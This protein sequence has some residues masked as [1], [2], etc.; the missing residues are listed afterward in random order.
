MKD[1]E[2]VVG[3]RIH[4][5]ELQLRRGQWRSRNAV[6]SKIPWRRRMSLALFGCKMALLVRFLPGFKGLLVMRPQ[7]D[8][9]TE[10]RLPR[11]CE[12]TT[13]W[14]SGRLVTA[15]CGPRWERRPEGEELPWAGPIH[16]ALGGRPAPANSI[17]EK[18]SEWLGCDWPSDQNPS[19]F[20]AAKI[21]SSGGSS[22]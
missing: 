13:G 6:F 14:P 18:A 5:S 3:G 9:F 22:T 11:L 16:V 20:S 1:S 8:P 7:R 12:T 2:Q 10:R 17:S 21:V 15:N 4:E 19:G